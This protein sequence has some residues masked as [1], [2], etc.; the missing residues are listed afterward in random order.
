MLMMVTMGNGGKPLA[1]D[2]VV[3]SNVNRGRALSQ[4]EAE[5]CSRCNGLISLYLDKPGC[6]TIVR[7]ARAAEACCCCKVV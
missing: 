2:Y 6:G 3:L 1:K 5:K 4:G 7:L